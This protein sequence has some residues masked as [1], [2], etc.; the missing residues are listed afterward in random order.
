MNYKNK[1]WTLDE[2]EYMNWH[3]ARIHSLGIV[4]DEEH[5]QNKLSLDIDYILEWIK[6]DKGGYF[7][8]VIPCILTFYDV[9][10]LT[11]DISTGRTTT[12]NLEIDYIEMNE[13][14][15]LDENDP[16]KTISWSI[17][18]Q[19]GTISFEAISFEQIPSIDMPILSKTQSLK[20]PL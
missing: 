3:D 14:N 7:F 20:R 11:I 10:D 18:L 16:F 9:H 12:L 5:Y 15:S 1:I 19:N 2:F 4:N 13:Y 8:S 6:N 17:E